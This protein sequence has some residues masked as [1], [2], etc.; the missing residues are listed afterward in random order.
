MAEFFDLV[1]WAVYAGAGVLC[2]VGLFVLMVAGW[3]LYWIQRD[4][5]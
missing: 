3:A 2:V 4:K 1:K 5:R